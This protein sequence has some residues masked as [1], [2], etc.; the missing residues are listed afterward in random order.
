MITTILF[1]LDGTIVDTNELIIAS[2]LHSLQGQTLEPFT[3][4]HIIPNMGKPLME[5]MLMFT[6]KTEVDDLIRIYREYNVRMH[7]ELVRE[8]PHVREVLAKLH[9]NGIRMGVVTNKVRKTTEMG[10]KL[11]QLDRYMDTIVT[12]EDVSKA[13]PDPEGIQVALNRLNAKPEETL[14]VGDSQYD[15]QSGQNAG[16]KAAGVAWSMKGANFLRTFHPDYLLDDMRD[17]LD[18]AGIKRDEI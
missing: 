6:G 11:F 14:M 16:V 7:D 18:I 1:D 13:K 9:A 10:L 2:F 15:I 8:F 5:Q 12:V 17:L 3:R 4:D